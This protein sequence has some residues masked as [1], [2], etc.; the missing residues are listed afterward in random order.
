MKTY[1]SILRGINVSGTKLIKMADLK[2]LYE[3]LGYRNVK[4][5]I[6]S[7]NVIFDS[8]SNKDIA[9]SIEKAITEK[10]NFEV[11]VILRTAEELKDIVNKNIFIADK[12]TDVTKLHVTFMEEEPS[13]AN[14]DKI[15]DIDHLPDK[16]LISGKE[17]NVY[18]PNGYGK[19][20][21][22]NNYFENKLKVS[23]T[24]RNWRTLN[25]LLNMIEIINLNN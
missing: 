16:F 10:Y 8:E 4:T 6:Q 14:I 18:C 2:L 23:C 1:L 20:K 11:P 13:Y 25:E 5:Y 17:I 12:D 7:G 24:T 3:S 9:K 22:N 21:I 19:T 15:K